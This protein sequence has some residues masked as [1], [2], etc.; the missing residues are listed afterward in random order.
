MNLDRVRERLSQVEDKVVYPS[1]IIIK[2]IHGPRPKSLY[3]DG[4]YI[5][6]PGEPTE[7]VLARY[8]IESRR[9]KPLPVIRLTLKYP[10]E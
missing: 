9:G 8:G 4:E 6:E 1:A 3:S 10:A 2:E 7:H 5:A